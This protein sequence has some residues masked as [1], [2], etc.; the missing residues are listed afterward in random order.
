MSVPA[1]AVA[2]AV[3]EMVRS[4][5]LVA[6]SVSDAML[7]AGVVSSVGLLAVMVAVLRVGPGSSGA[8]ARVRLKVV[9]ALEA[10]AALVVHVSTPAAIVQRESEVEPVVLAG[11][12]SFT[13][14]PGGTVDGPL[15]FRVIA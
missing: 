13:T 11:I 12:V 9:E 15:F 3:F 6:V 5:D 7:L 4:A 2:G 14:T 10:S 1:V 8:T